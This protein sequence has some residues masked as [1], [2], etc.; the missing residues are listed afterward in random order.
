[1]LFWEDFLL[2]QEW[3]LIVET[4]LEE[5]PSPLLVAAIRELNSK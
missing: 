2:R 1:M 3:L 5:I 4:M